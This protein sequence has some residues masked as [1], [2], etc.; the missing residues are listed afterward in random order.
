MTRLL[1]AAL[2]AL[3]APAARAQ[4]CTTTWT[5]AAGGAWETATNWTNGVPGASSTACITLAGTYTVAQSSADRTIAGLVLGGTSGTQTL[6]TFNTFSV[7][8]NSFVRPNGRWELLNR[9]PGGSDGFLT[10]GTATI[11]GVFVQNGGTT[12]LDGGGTLD[13][14]PGGRWE[15]RGQASAGIQARPGT[16]RLRGTLDAAYTSTQNVNLPLDVQ[17][18]TIRVS[19]GRLDIAGGT[20]VN[21][22]VDAAVGATLLLVGSAAPF[23]VSGTLGGAPAGEVIFTGGTVGAAAGGATLNVSGTGVQLSGSVFLT[24]AGGAFVNT[25]LLRKAYTGSNFS[26]FSGV[27]VT[28]RGT[29]DFPS[30]QLLEGAVLRNE[31]GATVLLPAGGSLNGTG[32]LDNVGLILRQGN[33]PGV[34]GTYSFN[35]QLRSLPGSEIRSNEDRVD[36]QTP[37]SRSIPDG[38]TLTGTGKFLFGGEIEGAVSPGTSERPLAELSFFSAFRLSL[39][40]GSPRVVVDVDAGGRSDTLTVGFGSGGG[41]TRLG[42]ALVVRVRPGYTPVV[43]DAW[44]I[45]TSESPDGITGQFSQVVAEGAPSGIAFVTERAPNGGSL[46]LRAVAVAAGGAVTV[47]TTRPVGGGVRPIFLSGPG[48]AGVA[49]ARLECTACLDPAAYG[50]IPATLVG[51]GGLKE[52]RFDLTSPRAFGLYDLVMVRPGL[53]DERVPV[54][55][56]PYVSYIQT[57]ASITRGIGVRPASTGQYNWSGYDVFNT[58]NTPEPS[59]TFAVAGREDRAQVDF[60][61]ASG[62]AFVPGVV[63]FYESRTAADPTAGALTFARIPSGQSVPLSYGLRTDPANI[64]F[65][66]Q[67]PTGTS[68]PRIRFGDNRVF[69]LFAVQHTSFSRAAGVVELTLRSTQ[70]AALQIY[71]TQVDAAD[72]GAVRAGIG[73]ALESAPRYVGG[74]ADLLGR[75]LAA[76]NATVAVPAGL[77]GQAAAE[78]ART[79]DAAAYRLYAD[80]EY[81]YR[82]DLATAPQAVRDLLAAEYVALGGASSLDAAPTHLGLT[83]PSLGNACRN[84]ANI[85][86]S[87]TGAPPPPSSSSVASVAQCALQS[88]APPRPPDVPVPGPISAAANTVGNTAR[89]AAAAIRAASTTTALPRPGGGGSCGGGGAGGGSGGGAGGGGSCTPPSAPAD[90]ND[91]TAE[92]TLR[93]QFGTVVVGGVAQ[94]RCVRYFVPL[95]EAQAPVRY[96]IQFENL[97]QATAPA[98]FVTVTDTLDAQFNPA[99]L[100]VLATSSDSTFTYTVAGQVVT[101]RFTG[102]DLP[103]NVTAPEGQGFITYEV[104]PRPTVVDGSVLRNRASIVFDFNPAIATPQ[105]VHEVRQTADLSAV[106]DAPDFVVVGQPQAF[107]VVVANTQGDAAGA[108]SVTIQ[109]GGLPGVQVTTTGGTCSG[110]APVVCTF[111]ALAG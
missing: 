98:E 63:V 31:P 66:E 40:A 45:L 106:I 33:R 71:L 13:I 11:E 78:F 91:K 18:G 4:T 76:M 36:L 80:L 27:V 79:L 81:A 17:G 95:A 101:F 103:P 32:R 107:T 6:T 54:T 38:T 72:A 100:R 68:D 88:P 89:R 2:L 9:T 87:A 67:T 29:V 21:A 102:I 22:T 61:V 96:T 46:V 82:I 48:A 26:G 92:T 90:P 56:R 52:A 104:S 12:L 50:S 43:G 42:G 73:E 3:F 109:T 47:S 55:V 105:V 35:G 64:L 65:P 19:Q 37:A 70:N 74:T 93:C 60:A 62:N 5:N 58:T 110:T 24:S 28:N 85:A 99:T 69:N 15:M 83:I 39:V 86:R 57:S 59:Y 1:L 51:A 34:G 75:T 111:G 49:S 77:S 10:S 8:G 97:P 53:A 41:N 94:T 25:G 23:T 14:A 7:T 20:L 108:A 30:F 44:T 16:F 84:I